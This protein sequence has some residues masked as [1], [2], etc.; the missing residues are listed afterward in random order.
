MF[1]CIFFQIIAFDDLETFIFRVINTDFPT[2]E[3]CGQRMK[4]HTVLHQIVL[5]VKMPCENRSDPLFFCP[6]HIVPDL[7]LRQMLFMR[8]IRS[9]E[10][11]HDPVRECG[12]ECET[13]DK[14]EDARDPVPQRDPQQQ[15]REILPVDPVAVSEQ[16]FS[17]PDITA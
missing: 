11:F 15:I 8:Q 1:S 14:K 17:A 5:T 7:I 13:G 12:P 3:K 6:F 2:V 4:R 16:N 10:S 9:F